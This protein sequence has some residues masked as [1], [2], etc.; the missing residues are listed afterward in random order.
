MNAMPVLL[1]VV[2]W[3]AA[4]GPATTTPTSG[5]A[6]TVEESARRLRDAIRAG[7]RH[8]TRSLIARSGS[9]DPGLLDDYVELLLSAERLRDAVRLAFPPKP[10]E[11]TDSDEPI[12]VLGA[13]DQL[14]EVRLSRDGEPLRFRRTDLGWQIDLDAVLPA[15]RATDVERQRELVRGLTRVFR[16]L[17][18][19]LAAER[20]VSLVDL[21]AVLAMRTNDL[22][23]NL[24]QRRPTTQPAR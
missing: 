16:E 17:R 9:F 12:R 22:L 24:S 19:E 3:L 4:A 18:D 20:Y 13:D 8:A 15:D 23:A 11:A 10:G 14:A 5:P 2:A 7:D 1:L 6:D 21:R